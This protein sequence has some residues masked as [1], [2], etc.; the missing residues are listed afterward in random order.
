MDEDAPINVESRK[1]LR[2]KKFME[3]LKNKSKHNSILNVDERAGKKPETTKLTSALQLIRGKENKAPATS[4]RHEAKKVQ[5]SG[6]TDNQKPPRKPFVFR[7]KENVLTERS[8]PTQSTVCKKPTVRGTYT[9]PTLK[10]STFPPKA[11]KVR[12][13][14]TGKVSSNLSMAK[15][16]STT[17]PKPTVSSLLKTYT[18]RLSLGPMVKTRTGLVPALIHPRVPRSLPA[19]DAKL[20]PSSSAVT[21]SKALVKKK[22]LHQRQVVPRELKSTLGEQPPCKSRAKSTAVPSSHARPF[23]RL[24][25]KTTNQPAKRPCQPQGRP[26]T[27]KSGVV[28]RTSQAAASRKPTVA[29][30]KLADVAPKGK[31][32][33]TAKRTEPCATV[34]NQSKLESKATKS[35]TVGRNMAAEQAERMKKLQEWREAKGISYKRPPMQTKPS[36]GRVLSRPHSSTLKAQE[37]A[38]LFIRD[39]DRSLSDCMKLLT[40]GCP[41]QVKE[42]LSRLPPVSRKFA[43]FWICKA[44]LMEQEG[45]L[46]VLPMYEEAVR[47]VLEPVDELRVVVFDI[48]K[49]K[50][51]KASEGDDTEADGTP[52]KGRQIENGQDPTVTPPVRVLLSGEAGASSTVKY[53]ITDTPGPPSRQQREPRQADGHEVRFFTPVRRS[54]R[55]EGGSRCYPASLQEHDQCVAS[56]A[57]LLATEEE[58]EARGDTLFVYRENEALKDRMHV[59]LVS[60]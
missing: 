12:I 33:P 19:A 27:Q 39:V 41:A 11:P 51:T 56:F 47:I 45:D 52:S 21:S 1:E 6:L 7:N 13:Q 59:R 58:E 49:K 40:E 18:S 36:V 37:D 25:D 43:R 17:R 2:K 55:I 38:G 22:P 14:P 57:E 3:Y 30:P 28:G 20:V 23:A 50:E 10:A 4:F 24:P 35:Q 26:T 9:V 16:P 29:K 8:R 48:L 42:V 60:D 53:K 54:I 32:A 15:N 44:R 46:D 31:S 5:P 34:V